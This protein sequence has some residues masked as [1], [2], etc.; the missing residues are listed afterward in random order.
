MANYVLLERIELN[1]SAA[2][3]TFSNIPQSGYTDLKIVSSCRS[4][5][6]TSANDG[7]M[8]FNGSTTGYSSRLLYGL[9]SGTPASASNSGTYMYWIN[10]SDANGLTANT[11]ASSEI[12]IPNY[13]SSSAKSVSFDGVTENNGTYGAQLMTAGLW[14]GTAAISS[15]SFTQDYGNYIAGTTFSLYGLAATGTTPVIAPKASGGSIYSD[16]TYWYHAFRTSGTF[17]PQTGISADVLVVAG[18][19]GGGG[20]GVGGGGGAGGLL[21]FTSQSLS[22]TAYTCTIGAG[23]A[24]GTTGYGVNGNSSVFGALTTAVGGGGGATGTVGNNGGS[25]GGGGIGGYAGGTA[26]SGQGYNGGLGFSSTTGTTRGGGGGGGSAAVGNNGASGAGGTGGSGVSTYSSWANATTSG[27][28]GYYAGGG[29]AGSSAG[30]GTYAG[31]NG[32]GGTGSGSGSVVGTDATTNTG[33]GGGGGGTTSGVSNSAGG[34]GG[35]GIVIIRY[36]I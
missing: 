34:A 25:G 5:A 12:Y 33:S 4:D 17:T 15:I 20:T 35:S 11:F 21:A 8:T 26:T 7:H 30:S 31:G 18:G 3:V 2:S 24:G 29:G 10:A 28:S 23:G 22:A 9:G 16:G 32:G 19:G 1:A 14:S 36:A 13:L 27:S 6:G